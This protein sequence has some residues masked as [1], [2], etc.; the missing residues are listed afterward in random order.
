MPDTTPISV[1]LISGNE[2]KRIRPTLE[3]VAG[4]AAEI[5]ILLNEDVADGTDKIAAEFGAKVYREPWKGFGPQKQSVADKCTQPWLL[6]LDADEVISPE[7]KA[8]ITRL[9]ADE[10]RSRVHA[11]Y[12]FPRCTFYC[13]RWIRH[14]NWYPDRQIRLW[15]RGQARWSASQVHEKLE[16]G[17]SI[18]RLRG[19]LQHHSM[20]SLD[21]HIRKVGEYS[22]IFARQRAGR[23]VGVFE[24][25]IR[26]WWRFVRSYILRAGFLDGWQGYA[27]ARLSAHDAFLRNAK[28]LEARDTAAKSSG[29]KT[30]S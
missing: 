9:L 24:L 3:S 6:N 12:E 19:E 1:C 21:H 4:W 16:V 23:G 29:G 22:T 8:E 20:D 17:G 14:G 26:P 7:L 5:V 30:P 2:A 27:V 25:V 28:I 13:G 11:A 15:Q 18:G 10:R